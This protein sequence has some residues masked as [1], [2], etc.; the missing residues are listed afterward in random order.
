MT[1]KKIPYKIYLHEE[2]MP[3]RRYENQTGAAAESGHAPTR[4]V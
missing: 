4:D 3:K 1:S 2:E